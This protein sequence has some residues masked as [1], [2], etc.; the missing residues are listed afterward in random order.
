MCL[1]RVPCFSK[2][3]FTLKPRFLLVLAK[4]KCIMGY[5]VALSPALLSDRKP[6]VNHVRDCF[7]APKPAASE[8]VIRDRNGTQRPL[9]GTRWIFA[10]L[11]VLFCV[12]SHPLFSNCSHLN[13]NGS[14]TVAPITSWETES[15]RRGKKEDNCKETPNNAVFFG[16]CF[17]RKHSCFFFLPSFLE[18]KQLCFKRNCTV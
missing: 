6:K 9:A 17:S 18:K 2:A 14:S 3:V 15:D 8:Q 5:L 16:R 7:W 10:G 11:W 13:Q 1:D 12:F 4:V